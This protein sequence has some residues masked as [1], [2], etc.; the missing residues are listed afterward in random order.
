MRPGSNPTHV[1]PPA[2]LDPDGAQVEHWEATEK[3]GAQHLERQK[4]HTAKRIW[5]AL[6]VGSQTVPEA[7]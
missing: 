4:V 1:D 5:E 7:G 6:E 2:P 3:L